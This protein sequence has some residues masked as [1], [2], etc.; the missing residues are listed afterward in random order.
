MAQNPMITR[1]NFAGIGTQ[2]I[3]EAGRVAV[4]DLFRRSFGEPS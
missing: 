3:S 1:E 2:E 4:Q